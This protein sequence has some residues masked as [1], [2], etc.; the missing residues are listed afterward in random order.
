M[1]VSVIYAGNLALPV[2][3]NSHGVYDS[4]DKRCVK[5]KF[6]VESFAS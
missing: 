4:V 6:H 1:Y 3:L 5:K 2:L